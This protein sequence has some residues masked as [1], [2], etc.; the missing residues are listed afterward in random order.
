M[1]MGR[2]LAMLARHN[3]SCFHTRIRPGKFEKYVF[4]SQKCLGAL[5]NNCTFGAFIQAMLLREHL[6]M[7]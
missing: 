7:Y 2:K 4:H 3:L 6:G 1:S 5:W